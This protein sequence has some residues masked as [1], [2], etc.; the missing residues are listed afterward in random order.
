MLINLLNL[1]FY[2]S[3]GSTWLDGSL[4]SIQLVE[5]RWQF[6]AVTYDGFSLNIYID[7]KL[8]SSKA[9]TYTMPITMRTQNWFGKSPY[10]QDGYSH[11]Y[12]DDIKFYNTS[13]NQ[14]QINSIM[15]N[16]IC[17]LED[18]VESLNPPSILFAKLLS[19]LVPKSASH[20]L[21]QVDSMT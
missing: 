14:T 10:S 21:S 8:T 3:K 19:R 16:E 1:E 20:K 7:G 17:L 12:I 11:S 18:Q 9:M 6:L 13:L 4:S 15:N 5:N 2:I